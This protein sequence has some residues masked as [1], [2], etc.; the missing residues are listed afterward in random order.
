MTPYLPDNVILRALI[1][2]VQSAG[3]L[4][5]ARTAAN[6]AISCMHPISVGV[7]TGDL[8][9]HPIPEPNCTVM[10]TS[11]RENFEGW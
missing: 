7:R 6:I 5:Q 11:G 3:T 2:A 8:N 1:R 4:N 9:P 10:A